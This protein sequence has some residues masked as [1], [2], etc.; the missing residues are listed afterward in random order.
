MFVILSYLILTVC[1]GSRN[2][3]HES[4]VCIGCRF[5][6]TIVEQQDYSETQTLTVKLK[7]ASVSMKTLIVNPG[8]EDYLRVLLLLGH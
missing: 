2:P 7:A 4:S 5:T 8:G 3:L 1:S 6:E